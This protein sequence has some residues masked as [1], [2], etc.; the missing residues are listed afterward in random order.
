M[1]IVSLECPHTFA[2]RVVS[3]FTQCPIINA[4]QINPHFH[5]RPALYSSDRLL[6]NLHRYDFRDWI[7]NHVLPFRWKEVGPHRCGIRDCE[8]SAGCLFGSRASR[9]LVCR[10]ARTDSEHV[11]RK[12]VRWQGQELRAE[13]NWEVGDAFLLDKKWRRPLLRQRCRGRRR[14]C[15]G[16]RVRWRIGRPRSWPCS[17]S[18]MTGCRS[19]ASSFSSRPAG[20]TISFYRC[21]YSIDNVITAIRFYFHIIVGIY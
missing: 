18:S 12:V 15:S 1:Q 9:N 14:R 17:T 5:A 4:F 20:R 11:S 3:F 16:H 10:N 21:E 8:R 2:Q 6:C 13:L 7:A 19:A